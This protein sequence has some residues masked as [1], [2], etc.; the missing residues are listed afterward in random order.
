MK[1]EAQEL[2]ALF[3]RRSTMTQKA[4]GQAFELGTGSMVWQYLEGRRP[5][6]LMAACRFANGLGADLAEFSPRLAKELE[7][8]MGLAF[9]ELRHPSSV[10][11]PEY[12]RIPRV[13]L[14]I[15]KGMPGFKILSLHDGPSF[16]AFRHDWLSERQYPSDRLIGIESPDDGM[17]PTLGQGDL[18]I[19]HTGDV[20]LV[21]GQVFAINYE[22]RLVIRR[23]FRDAGAWWLNCDNTDSRHFPRKQFLSK[24]C[25]IIGR[26]VYRQSEA[27]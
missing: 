13:D 22:G 23:L 16:I 25:F 18:V 1:S 20:R 5:L 19:L 10:T 24:H 11:E 6:N 14:A 17:A 7:V 15:K 2:R 21:D 3:E 12:A 9:P 4:F 27:I 26:A 8:A